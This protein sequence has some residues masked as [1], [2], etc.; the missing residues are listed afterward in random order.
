MQE[1]WISLFFVTLF[2]LLHI[3]RPYIKIFR[4]IDGLAWLPLLS[5]I[6][7]LVIFPAYGFRPE[8]IPLLIYSAILAGM[9]FPKKARDN[10]VFKSSRRTRSIF[11]LPPLV[12]LA[13][14][15]AAA[16]YFTPLVDTALINEGVYSFKI[17]PAGNFQ[18]DAGG[19]EYFIRI[20]TDENDTRP[21]RRP[22][23]LVIPP[24]LG[25]LRSVDIVCGE[26][27]DRGFT[28]LGYSRRGFDSPAIHLEERYGI[29]P[30]EWFRRIRAFSS[31]NVSVNA[32]NYGRALEEKRSGDL[33][34]LLDWIQQNPLLDTGRKL[35]DLASRDAIF[36]A[37]YDAGGSA[38]ILE[39]SSFPEK[40]GI[41]G[42]I[43]IESYMWSLYRGE[44]PI[45]GTLPP[46]ASWLSSVQRGLNRWYMEMKPKSIMGL[47]QIP[48]LSI[49]VL[50]LVSEKG[51]NHGSRYEA[52]WQCYESIRAPAVVISLDGSSMLHYG[53]YPV[54]YPLITTLLRGRIKP[55]YGT[56]YGPAGTADIIT[57]FAVSVL[58]SE[59][60]VDYYLKNNPPSKGIMVTPNAAWP[61]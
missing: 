36:L 54:K 19:D 52:I 53:D 24:A 4:I 26:L 47:G 29:N 17:K 8:L 10:I 22:L 42:I 38:L 16:F 6:I 34:F 13:V 21:S 61:P 49:P 5:F 30:A 28:V 3:L 50:F 9:N 51:G 20:Y 56:P 2:L 48:R 44:V 12:I 46:D 14:V 31:G 11:A 55:A 57:G 33:L 35:F 45:I 58:N 25:S 43:A 27:R 7:I 18:V 1:I 32:N 15:A 39:G 60:G 41:R 37:G 59:S 40:P 23:L